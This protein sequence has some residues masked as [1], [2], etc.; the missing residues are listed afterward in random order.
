MTCSS[1]NAGWSKCVA[2]G[3]SDVKMTSCSSH[4][5]G[6]SILVCHIGCCRCGYLLHLDSSHFGIK[7]FFVIFS[8]IYMPCLQDIS[9]NSLTWMMITD[10]IEENLIASCC[11]LVPITESVR[12]FY[13]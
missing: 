10:C 2:L 13:K 8:I 11:R 6:W 3:R 4:N 7:F 9:D 12:T 5:A 1:H